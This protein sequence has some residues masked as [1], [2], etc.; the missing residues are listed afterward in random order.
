MVKF[1]DIN[2]GKTEKP[3]TDVKPQDTIPE[4]KTDTLPEEALPS[5]N[6]AKTSATPTE[7]KPDTEP[8][9][10][11]FS[12][13]VTK[14]DSVHELIKK[15]TSIAV[16]ETTK[17]DISEDTMPK[18]PEIPRAT[19]S[20][21]PKSPTEHSPVSQAAYI[22]SSGQRKH[23]IVT[24]ILSIILIILL[25]LLTSQAVI[26]FTQTKADTTTVPKQDPVVTTKT[27]ETPKT[28]ETTSTTT[29]TTT[30]APAT[31]ETTTA[32]AVATTTDIT[33]EKATI[34]ILN[35]SGVSGAAAK[36]SAT[37]K[38]AG[39]IVSSTGN[40]KSFTYAT[41]QILYKSDS[42]KTVAEDV[43]KTLS[44]YTTEVKKDTIPSKD[45]EIIVIIGK[46]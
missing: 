18:A 7:S 13:S 3:S 22:P 21:A 36:V 24:A 9:R 16:A 28:T 45:T 42:A 10:P 35:G 23:K 17:E 32:P 29:T 19:A 15:E 31:T 44:T 27:T 38:A 37:L 6:A 4:A 39:Y 20:M 30:T 12:E 14:S 2:A 26:Y 11:D 40:A 5:E 25:A 34:K 8:L 46:K 33:K 1:Y 43:A 41:T